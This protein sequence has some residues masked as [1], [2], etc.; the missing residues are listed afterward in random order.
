MELNRVAAALVALTFISS[1]KEASPAVTSK[2]DSRI[3]WR[4]LADNSFGWFA[5]DDNSVNA[6]RC[7]RIGSRFQ[8]VH[9]WRL[10][11]PE[12]EVALDKNVSVSS[13]FRDS[14]QRTNSY[15]EHGYS[16]SVSGDGAI[17]RLALVGGAEIQNT[18]SSLGFS[19]GKFWSPN[20]VRNFVAQNSPSTPI[21]Y[22]RCETVQELLRSGNEAAFLTTAI[23]AS[24]LGLS[25]TS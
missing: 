10:Y 22:F 24:D 18:V 15:P 3:N 9:L 21:V 7:W 8:C 1:C 25:S 6:E 2:E 19:G 23:K 14:L 11:P 16:C 20:Y 17:E 12:M 5:E 4:K 13:F